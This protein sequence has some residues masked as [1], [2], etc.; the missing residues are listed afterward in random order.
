RYGNLPC[1]EDLEQQRLKTLI[2]L[3]KFI[4]KQD[5]RAILVAQRAN[6]WPFGKEVESVQPLA[7][8]VPVF[9]QTFG[10][11]LQEEFLQC[12]VEL[13][14]RFLLGDSDV[15]LQSLYDGAG[16]FG[17]GVGKF[18]LAASRRS[19]DEKRFL[20]PSRQVNDRKCDRIDDVAR[21]PES[22][23]ELFGRREHSSCPR[24]RRLHRTELR[25]LPD[26]L[27][28]EIRTGLSRELF[29]MEHQEI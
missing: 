2:D 14:D 18:R 23:G 5:A 13:P 22:F 20:H 19:L 16:S 12:F 9:L 8:F 25:F 26:M 1:T 28:S 24:P 3:V 7:H 17:N 15:A 4:D 29:V 11:S 6:Q 21:S 10:L 27:A